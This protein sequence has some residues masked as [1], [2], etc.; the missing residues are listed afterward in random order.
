MYSPNSTNVGSAKYRTSESAFEWFCLLSD[1][2][3]T[4][5]KPIVCR[6]AYNTTAVRCSSAALSTPNPR[7]T[8]GVQRDECRLMASLSNAVPAGTTCKIAFVIINMS[9]RGCVFVTHIRCKPQT[10]GRYIQQAVHRT[11]EAINCKATPTT[12]VVQPSTTEHKSSA[13]DS[14]STE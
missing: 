11:Q 2:V 7:Q 5:Q 10:D 6:L 8:L 13:T 14:S 1:G 9:W 12:E 4:R 3:E